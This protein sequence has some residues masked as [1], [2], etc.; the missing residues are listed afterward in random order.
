MTMTSPL[1]HNDL[2]VQIKKT[3]LTYEGAQVKKAD[4]TAFGLAL[5]PPLG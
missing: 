1:S 2:A 4:R 5:F 3:G